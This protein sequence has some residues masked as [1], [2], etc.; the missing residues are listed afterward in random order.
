MKLL[1]FIKELKSTW[2]T[3]WNTKS[4]EIESITKMGR[5]VVWDIEM[6]VHHNFFAN[7]IIAHNCHMV[8]VKDYLDSSMAEENYAEMKKAKRTNYTQLLRTLEKRCMAKYGKKLRVFGY[9]G[10]P[11]RDNQEIINEDMRSP[12]YWRKK[13]INID[14]SYLQSVGAVVPYRFGDT[15]GLRYDLSNFHTSGEDGIQD[16]SDSDLAAMQD[17]ILKQGTLTQKIMLDVQRIAAER[18]SVLVTCSGKKHCEEAAAALLPGTTY[19]IITDDM[20]QKARTEAIAG[21]KAGKYKYTFQI[22]CLTTGVN[23]PVWDVGVILRRIG[24]ITLLTQLNGRIIRLFDHTKIDGAIEKNDALILDY[25][26]TMED[27]GSAFSDPQ[28]EQYQHVQA[29]IK[30][31][32]QTCPEC[33]TKNSVYARRCIG[34]DH[35]GIRCEYFFKFRECEDYFNQSTG[36]LIKQGCGTKNDPCARFCRSCEGT[37]IDPNEKLSGTHYVEGEFHNVVDMKIELTKDQRALVFK[38]KLQSPDNSVFFASELFMPES[39]HV[40]AKNKFRAE[41]IGKHVM[42]KSI[43]KEMRGV[44]N[45][46]RLMKYAKFISKPVRVS[47]RKNGKGKDIIANKVFDNGSF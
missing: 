10:S 33:D 15:S 46:V 9:T 34:K 28:L 45:A 13:L 17:E 1:N 3:A 35:M 39:E 30:D 6:P 16:F 42:N 31:E 19:V 40:W 21:I 32:W 4:V 14:T 22:G 41:V 20:G 12:G 36:K 18:N 37:L 11:W 5:N 26:G 2:L 27:L 25:S 7:G 29:E 8:N 47:H 44:S 24:S 23:V 38:Y 43:Q